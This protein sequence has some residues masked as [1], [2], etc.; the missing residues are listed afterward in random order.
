MPATATA[1]VQQIE[2]LTTDAE[3]ELRRY[4]AELARELR[5]LQKV[6]RADSPRYVQMIADREAID[7]TIANSNAARAR[8]ERERQKQEQEYIRHRERREQEGKEY[9]ATV[10]EWLKPMFAGYV[11]K[12]KDDVFLEAAR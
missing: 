12:P 2:P 8:Q 5:L 7:A 1:A 4:G 3:K 6:G 9:V 11:C 10:V